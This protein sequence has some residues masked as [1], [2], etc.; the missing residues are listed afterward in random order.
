MSEI[1]EKILPKHLNIDNVVHVA[2]SAPLVAKRQRLYRRS[3][4]AREQAAS[5]HVY[6][7]LHYTP[8]AKGKGR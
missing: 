4:A 3:K 8:A 7:C 1:A 2:K 5:E 6:I